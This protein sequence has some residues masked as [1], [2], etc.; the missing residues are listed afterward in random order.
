MIPGDTPEFGDLGEVRRVQQAGGYLWLIFGEAGES[1]GRFD[2]STGERQPL[3]VGRWLHGSTEHDG[4]LWLTSYTDDLLLRVD[5]ESGDVR[6]YALP[7]RPGGVDSTDGDLWILLYQPGSLLRI[8]PSEELIEMGPEVAAIT[9]ETATASPHTLVCTLG[10]VDAE[11]LQKAQVDRDFTGLGSTIVMEGPSWMSG[12]IWSVVQAQVEGRVVCVSGHRGEG[13]TP[14]QR[15]AD[16]TDALGRADIPG[17]YQLVAAGDGVHTIRLFADGRDDVTGVVLV[18]PIP[19]GFQS[20]YDGLLGEDF[21]H[22][23]WA[24]LDPAESESLSGFGDIPLVILSHDPNAVFLSDVFVSAAGEEDARTVS[25]Y[26][27][28][29]MDYYSALST[30]T[31]R[32]MIPDTGFEGV[33]W[34]RPEMVVRAIEGQP[35]ESG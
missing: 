13:G 22:P 32:V 3:H 12:G 20:F 26:W 15:A 5:P 31:R 29:G 10:G 23:G 4:A 21:A 9:S 7:G 34:Y 16:L 19:I 33:L 27:E 14:Q 35:A 17:P 11:T 8:D 30:D 28:D 25:A 2:P 1:V 6:T 18:E 24:D